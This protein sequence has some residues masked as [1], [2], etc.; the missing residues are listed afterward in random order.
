[1]EKKVFSLE[2]KTSKPVLAICYDFDKTLSPDDMQAQ[3]YIQ[4]VGCDIKEFWNESNQL[5]QDNDMDQNSAYMLKM[6]E[7]SHGKFY[8][9]KESLAKYGSEVKLFDGVETWFDRIKRYGRSK[10]VIVEH[11]IISS[12]LKE[13]IEG[14]KMAQEGAFKRIYASSYYYDKDNVA[15][16]PAQVVNYTNKT[17]FLF[18]IEK[19]VLDVNDDRVNNYFPPEKI[20]I[21]FRNMVYIGDSA[22]DIPCMKLVNTYGGYS[23]GV[24]NPENKDKSKV[25][26]MISENRI[27][28]FAPADYTEDSELDEL[29]KMIIDRTK[30]NE[31]LEN[32]HYKYI[33]E[34]EEH[35]TNLAEGL[36]NNL[37]ANLVNSRSYAATHTAISQLN[38]VDSWNE[39]QLRNLYEAACNNGQVQ[40]IIL[41]SDVRLFFATLLKR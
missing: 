36:K 11:Y 40:T 8:L 1:M 10:G 27:K 18:R 34:V 2:R 20:R 13:M 3:G 12:G 41:D 19:G 9:T 21:P 39:E 7:K 14:T 28:Y 35:R 15:V 22:T 16:W 4:S 33:T 32:Q 37:I 17:Q 38:E 5:A 23:I 6:V 30:K 31:L 24:Y 26:S 29:I 25:Y